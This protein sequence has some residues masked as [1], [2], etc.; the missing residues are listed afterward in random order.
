MCNKKTLLQQVEPLLLLISSKCFDSHNFNLLS[1]STTSRLL[2]PL[3][4]LTLSI[5]ESRSMFCVYRHH[6]PSSRHHLRLIL[7]H[8]HDCS[9]NRRFFSHSLFSFASDK[10]FGLTLFS[11]IEQIT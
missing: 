1:F 8:F 2:F 6:S 7:L 5:C 3:V 11:V 10:L 9:G 4:S